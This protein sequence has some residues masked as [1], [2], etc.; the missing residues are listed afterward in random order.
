MFNTKLGY[1]LKAELLYREVK[2]SCYK[3]LKN[4]EERMN[5]LIDFAE[6]LR[7][8]P[9][10]ENNTEQVTRLE[11]LQ[12]CAKNVKL[13]LTQ[14]HDRVASIT[15]IY[16][17]PVGYLEN[18][19]VLLNCAFAE[20]NDAYKYLDEFMDI[21][22]TSLSNTTIEDISE[23]DMDALFDIMTEYFDLYISQ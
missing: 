6:R 21:L 10:I 11:K 13:R 7:I 8:I 12:Q 16:L 17:V 18:C 4:Q 9:Y 15:S 5:N 20:S 22:V 23:A 3:T 1:W 19:M 14:A 2:S